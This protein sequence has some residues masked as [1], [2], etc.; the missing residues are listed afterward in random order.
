MVQIVKRLKH[1][2]IKEWLN[3]PHKHYMEKN[4]M[5]L[6]L[7]DVLS[8][9]TYKGKGTDR[10][11]ASIPIHLFEVFVKG[12]ASW[13]IARDIKGEGILVYSISDSAEILKALD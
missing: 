1:K 10:H 8:H 6:R 11:N 12:D 7:S 5:L 3:Q 4:E 9:S 2:G 13:I